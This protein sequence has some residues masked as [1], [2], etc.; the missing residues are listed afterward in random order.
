MDEK[1]KSEFG[2][3]RVRKH[4]KV[5]IIPIYF[6]AVNEG[7]KTYEVRKNDRNYTNADTITLQ[8]WDKEYTGRE[9]EFRIGHVLHLSDFFNN[10][11]RIT[12]HHKRV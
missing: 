1:K 10:E 5:K 4:H 7:R 12:P 11:A 2:V 6:D 9:L 3:N 8:E